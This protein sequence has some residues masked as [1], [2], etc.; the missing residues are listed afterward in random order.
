MDAI[1]Q[2][3]WMMIRTAKEKSPIPTGA[4]WPLYGPVAGRPFQTSF[5]PSP[6]VNL[7]VAQATPYEPFLEPL[8]CLLY[9]YI[10]TKGLAALNFLNKS[11]GTTEN[12]QATCG[13][14]IVDASTSMGVHVERRL[15]C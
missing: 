9:I 12:P 2:I 7:S 1:H 14:R 15:T 11:K 3:G 5:V 13:L 8:S 6:Q 10:Y 4:E